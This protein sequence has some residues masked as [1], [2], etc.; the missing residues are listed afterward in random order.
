MQGIIGMKGLFRGFIV[1]D[2]SENNTSIKKFGREK[3]YLNGSDSSSESE[4][5]I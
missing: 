2:W 5:E 1:K 4:S 3:W